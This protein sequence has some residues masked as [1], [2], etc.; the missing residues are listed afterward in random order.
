MKYGFGFKTIASAASGKPFYRWYWVQALE[1]I[2]AAGFSAIELPYRAWTFN[3]GRGGSPLCKE[4]LGIK[5]GGP[6]KFNELVLQCGLPEGV[7]ALHITAANLLQSMLAMNMPADRL[8][9]KLADHGEEA[10]S[11]LAQLNGQALILSPSPPIGLF[12]ALFADKEPE[13]LTAWVLD[14]MAETVNKIGRKAAE[15]KIKIYVRNE[16]FSFIRGELISDFLNRVAPNICFSPDLGHLHIAGADI[17]RLLVRFRDKLDFIV[18]KDSFFVD[19]VNAFE[20]RTPEHPQSGNN[21]RVW[22][23]LG[24]GAVPLLE[25]RDL[26]Q[27]QGYDRWIIFETEEGFEHAV[28]ILVMASYMRKNFP[29]QSSEGAGGLNG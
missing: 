16:F 4:S 7:P 20:S 3:D 5:Y 21:Q 1:W 12:R 13:E 15:L 24:R 29:A 8:F 10:L 19:K 18:F 9:D 6:A 25:I 2:G 11:V 14:S 22:C 26:L 28:S 23:E 27:K 17:G